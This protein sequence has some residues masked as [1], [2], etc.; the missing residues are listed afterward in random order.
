MLT[1]GLSKT[2]RKCL[3]LLITAIFSFAQL[4]AQSEVRDYTLILKNKKHLPEACLELSAEKH[5]SLRHELT[6]GRYYVLLQFYDIPTATQKSAIKAAKIRLLDYIPNYAYTASIPANITPQELENLGVRTVTSQEVEDKIVAELQVDLQTQTDNDIII[7][8]YETATTFKALKAIG[9]HGIVAERS[10]KHSYLEARVNF[11]QLLTLAQLPFVQYI[12]PIGEPEKLLG[13]RSKSVRGNYLNSALGGGLKGEGV[14]VGVG[15]GGSAAHIDFTGRTINQVQESNLQDDNHTNMVAGMLGGGGILRPRVKGIAPMAEII[16]DTGSDILSDSSLTANVAA[17]MVLTNNSYGIGEG[18][19]YSTYS[20]RYDDQL[21]KHPQLMH[22]FSVGNSGKNT[23]PGYPQGYNTVLTHGQSS[24]NSIGVA[25]INH[26]NEL[27]PSSS[28]GPTKDGRLKPEISAISFGFVSPGTNNGYD[29]GYGTSFAA[30]QVT[31]GLALL[32]EH[33]RNLHGTDPPAALMKAIICNTATDIGNPGPDYTYGFGKLNLRKAK[34]VLDNAQH[35]DGQIA[36]QQTQNRTISVPPNLNELKIMLYWPDTSATL[37]S[38]IDLVNDLDIR[39]IAPNNYVYLPL[40]LNPHPDKVAELALPHVDR[41]NNIEQVVISNPVPGNYTINASAYRVPYTPQEFYVTYEF[42]SPGI[43]ITSPTSGESIPGGGSTNYYFE[44]DYEGADD[45]DND[46]Q[47][48]DFTIEYSADDG[49]TWSVVNDTIDG[50]VRIFKWNKTELVGINSPDIL[51]RISKNNTP[52][53]DTVEQVCQLYD[54]VSRANFSITPLCN[55]EI[56]FEWKKIDGAV[57]YELFEYNSGDQFDINTPTMDT[58]IVVQYDYDNGKKWFAVKAVYPNNNHSIMSDAELFAPPLPTATTSCPPSSPSAL[59]YS[60]G[61]YHVQF[62]WEEATDDSG[63]IGYAIYTNNVPVDTVT[64][65]DYTLHDLTPGVNIEYC[66]RA[67][68]EHGNESDQNCFSTST[69]S[70]DFCNQDVLFVTNGRTLSDNEAII[71]EHLQSIDYHIFTTNKDILQNMLWDKNWTVIIS[72]E[73]RISTTDISLFDDV[74]LFVMNFEM[75]NDFS[76]SSGS[77]SVIGKT[78]NIAS[79]YHPAAAGMSG[80]FDFYIGD[81]LLKGAVDVA[82]DAVPITTYQNISKILFTY[83]AGSTMR[84]GRT[85]LQRRVS[86]PLEDDHIEHL[87]SKAWILLDAALSW[88]ANCT[89]ESPEPLSDVVLTPGFTHINVAWDTS[90]VAADVEE[91]AIYLDNV[92]VGTTEDNKFVINNI[93]PSRTYKVS[94]TAIN[95]RSVESTRM[96]EYTTTLTCKDLE[97]YVWLEGALHDQPT[98]LMRTDLGFRNLLPGQMNADSQ[99]VAV[100]KHPYHLNPWSYFGTESISSY[101]EHIVDW[102]LVSFRTAPQKQS[103]VFQLV[104]LL[105]EDGSIQFPRSCVNYEFTVPAYIVIE[106]RNHIAVMSHVPVSISDHKIYYDF[107]NKNAYTINGAG[108]KLLPS[109]VFA[110][111]AGDCEQRNDVGGHQ[112]DGGDKSP[113]QLN[114]GNFN[115]Y[116]PEDMNLDGDI[117]GVDK[118]LWFSNNGVYSSVPR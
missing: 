114:N 60:T 41:V 49:N 40:V 95:T 18:G 3:L 21:K 80:E 111:Y 31:G 9:K 116:A 91:Y 2:G 64:V 106:H 99:A 86:F 90:L 17:G 58:S 79:P 117:N 25:G 96:Y 30:P 5:L 6:E 71:Y 11:Q 100:M 78:V 4:A 14:T 51:V 12:E 7:H 29:N 44:W 43:T 75:L 82:P 56:L 83:E 48:E 67:I 98:N 34:A 77:A 73:A 97:L 23:Q 115:F 69:L 46:G 94:L 61:Q 88:V 85:A 47:C 87:S 57:S 103:E 66:V 63:V 93:S 16:L 8:L 62:E 104:G 102:V 42:V 22:V 13:T 38:D 112:V 92:L 81:Y 20:K 33:Y 26:Y 101:G 110:M 52:Y 65:L 10:G 53:S 113:W 55:D 109:G 84:Y 32:Y 72:P 45:Y 107:R 50:N 74:P 36:E 108:Q 15:D 89:L 39:V 70:Q 54:F 1:F 37:M 76:L 105:S 118:Q 24:K 19:A 28:R 59:T 27:Y 68:D 35:F